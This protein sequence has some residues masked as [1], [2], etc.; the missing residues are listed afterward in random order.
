MLSIIV[1]CCALFCIFR[2]VAWVVK[3]G[4][5]GTER[6]DAVKDWLKEREN[7]LLKLN[8]SIWTPKYKRSDRHSGPRVMSGVC[9]GCGSAMMSN[10]GFCTS[11]G[12]AA[13]IAV[14]PKPTSFAPRLCN[15]CGSGVEAADNYC[16]QC[17]TVVPEAAAPRRAECEQQFTLE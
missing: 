1:F 9:S 16:K 4:G 11:C 5:G 12:M 2:M 8:E 17:G 15:R 14:V 3:S 13:T 7:R 6:L 10:P